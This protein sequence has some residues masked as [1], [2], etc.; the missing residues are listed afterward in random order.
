MAKRILVTGAT[1]AQGGALVRQLLQR[2]F[3]VRALTRNP[4]KPAGQALAVLGAE[5]VAGDLDNEASL[6]QA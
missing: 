5:V 6:E 3:S 4:N 2:G 1:G